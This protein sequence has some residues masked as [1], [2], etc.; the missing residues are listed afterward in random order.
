MEQMNLYG[1]PGP[2]N[3]DDI[4]DTLVELFGAPTPPLRR[5]YGRV[6]KYLASQRATPELVRQRCAAILELWGAR[7]LTVASLEKHWT[8][9][10]GMVG[11]LTPRQVEAALTEKAHDDYRRH[12]ESIDW[13]GDERA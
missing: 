7:A 12:L 5:M 10:D 9:F 3:P 4:W 2:T 11:S 1:E 13:S 6:T 8:R